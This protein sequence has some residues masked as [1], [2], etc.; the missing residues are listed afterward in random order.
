MKYGTATSYA[1]FTRMWWIDR[2]DMPEG[3]MM[4]STGPKR[5]IGR[6]MTEDEAR[7]MCKEWNATHD[8]GRLSLKAEYEEE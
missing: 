1:V 5:T 3:I 2:P 6:S 8:Y 7:T 4:P